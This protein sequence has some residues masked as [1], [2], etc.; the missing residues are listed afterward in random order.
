MVK[1]TF[2]VY[3]NMQGRGLSILLRNIGVSGR[4]VGRGNKLTVQGLVR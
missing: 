1:D 2:D 4:S 3:L